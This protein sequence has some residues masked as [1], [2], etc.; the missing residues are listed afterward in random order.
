MQS[1]FQLGSS[2]V[3]R[4]AP[5]TTMKCSICLEQFPIITLNY[6]SCSH[7]HCNDCLKSNAQAALHSVPFVPAKCCVVIPNNILRVA[8][9]FTDDEMAQYGRLI[10]EVTNP[11]PKLYCHDKD[12]GAFIPTKSKT[13][14]IGE[15]LECGKKTCKTCREKSHWGPCNQSALQEAQVTEELCLQLAASKGWKRCPNC[16]NVVSK[17]GGC[18]HVNCK[19]GQWLCYACGEATNSNGTAHSC[20]KATLR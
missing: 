19:C 10:E 3:V 20:P 7:A 12:C 13:R 11:G 1:I 4:P 16:L 15:C 17:S 9:V 8:G 5:P 14:R 18:N 6:L 2:R